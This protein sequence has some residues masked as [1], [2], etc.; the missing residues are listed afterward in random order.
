MA[1]GAAETVV[2]RTLA[3]FG[4]IDALLNIA[5]AK[6]TRPKLGLLALMRR[7]RL[8]RAGL[9]ELLIQPFDLL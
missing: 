8:M 9:L 5:G 1:P 7:S 3:Q 4:R 6:M 2:G